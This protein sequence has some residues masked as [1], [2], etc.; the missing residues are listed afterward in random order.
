MF[1]FNIYVD[2]Y[3]LR[4]IFILQTLLELEHC[5]LSATARSIYAR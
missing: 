5:P 1:F 2:E 3:E 4:V